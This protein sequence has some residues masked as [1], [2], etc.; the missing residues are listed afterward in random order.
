MSDEQPPSRAGARF[1]VAAAATIL[2]G[3]AGGW[4][5]RN[6]LRRGIVVGV[7]V[8]TADVALRRYLARLPDV[9]APRDDQAEA[10]EVE[11]EPD[12]D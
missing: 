9:D 5:A 4:S 3:L 1:A 11:I 6:A 12:G 2:V 8:A 10:I 7:A